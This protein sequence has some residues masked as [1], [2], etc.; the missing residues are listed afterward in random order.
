MYLL[1]LLEL[2]IYCNAVDVTIYLANQW[3]VAIMETSVLIHPSLWSVN[4]CCPF[5]PHP[6]EGGKEKE[7]KEKKL[8]Q[9]LTM[10]G[11]IL[12]T[13]NWGIYDEKSLSPDHDVCL[14]P[15]HLPSIIVPSDHTRKTIS[16]PQVF[17]YFKIIFKSLV[18][19]LFFF[20][21]V[22]QSLIILKLVFTNYWF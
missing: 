18:L 8:N 14:L 21:V 22:L 11:N 12:E 19:F 3:M 2:H 1:R 17:H 7:K 10:W 16:L 6:E 9:I 20:S 13:E 4:L 15:P 5:L